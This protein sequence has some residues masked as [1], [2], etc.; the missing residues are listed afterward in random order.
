MLTSCMFFRWT[1]FLRQGRDRCVQRLRGFGIQGFDNPFI[2][3][4]WFIVE[5]SH[6]K[7]D[8]SVFRIGE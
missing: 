8:E 6:P 3:G 7:V 4:V 1:V 2:M 5:F